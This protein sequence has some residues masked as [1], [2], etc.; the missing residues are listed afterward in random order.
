M[1]S[2]DAFPPGTDIE[3][4]LELYFETG[5]LLCDTD[6][7]SV[8]AATLAN[9]GASPFTGERIL[10]SE[11]VQQLLSVMNSCGMLGYSGQFQFDVGLPAKSGMSGAVM[12]VIPGVMGACT[13]SGRLD[14][15]G[16]SV[17]GTQYCLELSKTLGLHN[18]NI[19]HKSLGEHL[20]KHKDDQKHSRVEGQLQ[21]YCA[22]GDIAE[23]RRQIFIRCSPRLL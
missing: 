16:N 11:T 14:K 7:M 4:T 20:M 23:I 5:A 15:Y 1:K 18:F 6:T 22:V 17:R 12:L 10:K 21:H 8:I 3:K 9:G 2:K 19:D 13:F